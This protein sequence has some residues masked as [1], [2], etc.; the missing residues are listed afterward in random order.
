M[1][2][3]GYAKWRIYKAGGCWWADRSGWFLVSRT[4]WAE[5]VA[6]INVNWF[7]HASRFDKEEYGRRCDVGNDFQAGDKAAA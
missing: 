3:T 5:A 1:D 7:H 6:Y 2:L 4:T